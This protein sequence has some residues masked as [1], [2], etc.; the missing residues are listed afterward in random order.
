[1]FGNIQMSLLLITLSH[2]MR[3]GLIIY[4]IYDICRFGQQVKADKPGEAVLRDLYACTIV[5]QG[6]FITMQTTCR[7][8][9]LKESF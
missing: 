7:I 4:I 6:V 3:N 2:V 1:M 5:Y 9:R 8:R